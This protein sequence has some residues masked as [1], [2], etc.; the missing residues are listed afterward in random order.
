M[1][2]RTVSASLFLFDGF[3]NK[4]TIGLLSSMRELKYLAFGTK[5]ETDRVCPPNCVPFNFSTALSA[6]SGLSNWT[7]PNPLLCPLGFLAT[8]ADRIGPCWTK[9]ECRTLSSTRRWCKFCMKL[10]EIQH[11][12]NKPRAEYLT[13]FLTLYKWRCTPCWCWK[14]LS[15]R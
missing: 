10:N 8:L 6:L 3:R 14:A 13:P 5:W 11:S 9:W 4:V 2:K 15:V 12:R 1:S 7:K